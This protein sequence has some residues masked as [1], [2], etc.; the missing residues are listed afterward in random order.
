M[1]FY[2]SEQFSQNCRFEE[3]VILSFL[4]VEV[5]SDIAHDPIGGLFGI[6]PVKDFQNNPLPADHPLKHGHRRQTAPTHFHNDIVSALEF[7]QF[8]RPLCSCSGGTS[9]GA[10]SG[11]G[12]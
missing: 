10:K 1:L 5:G 4:G 7:W 11:S 3:V 12:K 8:G 9:I 6:S 2:Q